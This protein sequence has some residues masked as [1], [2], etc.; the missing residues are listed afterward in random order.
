MTAASYC[1]ARYCYMT[2][3]FPLVHHGEYSY[4]LAFYWSTMENIPMCWPSIGPPWRIFLCAGLLLVHH[5]EDS[6]VLA[7]Y[8]ST[9]ENIP[10]CWPFGVVNSDGVAYLR[11][12]SCDRDDDD[13]IAASRQVMSQASH[14][15]SQA[16]WRANCVAQSVAK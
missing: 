6:Y 14:E 3:S 8:W 11:N 16:K 10:M 4:V 2:Q 1:F 5:R 7:F 13:K 9:M 15:A 12:M